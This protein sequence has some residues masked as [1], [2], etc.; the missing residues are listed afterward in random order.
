MRT[1]I[2]AAG[3]MVVSEPIRDELG[4]MPGQEVEV[5]PRDG[6]IELGA[7]PHPD[8]AR[9]PEGRG[10]GRA[11][12]SPPAPHRRAGPRHART[13]PA[14]IAADT[15]VVVAA[16]V[17]WHERHR[18]ARRP[19]EREEVRLIGQ[20]ALETYAV[21][22]RLRPPHRAPALVVT[23]RQS[24]LPVYP[25]RECPGPPAH[26]TRTTPAGG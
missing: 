14:V 24:A 19:L 18:P 3:R 17:S 9:A 7:D 23:P 26:L 25:G 16:L 10:S 13:R 5:S 1:T 22:T 12:G 20:V 21:L 11:R 8:A 4:L 15:S 2:D 6:R